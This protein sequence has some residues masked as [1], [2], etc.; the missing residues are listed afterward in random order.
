MRTVSYYLQYLLL[1]LVF[2]MVFARGVSDA[3]K[4]AVDDVRSTVVSH[5]HHHRRFNKY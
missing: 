5:K 1:P 4:D 2:L 3:F